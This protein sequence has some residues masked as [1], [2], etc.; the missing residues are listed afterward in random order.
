[1]S[2]KVAHRTTQEKPKHTYNSNAHQEYKW[3]SD[4]PHTLPDLPPAAL[5]LWIETER[6][7]LYKGVAKD[8]SILLGMNPLVW[9]EETRFKKRTNKLTG[10]V[11]LEKYLVR[12]R[13][14]PKPIEVVV[15]PQ[16]SLF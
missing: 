7:V 15:S 5:Q 10:E 3:I 16:R 6:E 2:L 13:P 11:E 1:M 4:A 9:P 12:I 8:G 14:K